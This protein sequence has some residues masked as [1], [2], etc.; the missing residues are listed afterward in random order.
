[1]L[2]EKGPFRDKV[3]PRALSSEEVVIITVRF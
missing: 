2:E 1:M 3:A